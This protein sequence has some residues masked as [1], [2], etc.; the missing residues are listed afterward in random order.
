VFLETL[1]AP[2]LLKHIKLS[3]VGTNSAIQ[4][5]RVME[6]HAKCINK[7]MQQCLAQSPQHSEACRQERCAR[8]AAYTAA[9]TAAADAVVF[10][11]NSKTPVQVYNTLSNVTVLRYTA[12]TVLHFD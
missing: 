5:F 3:K 8:L 12:A 9:A 2:E 6:Q 4:T 11:T 10:T 1:N 7:V